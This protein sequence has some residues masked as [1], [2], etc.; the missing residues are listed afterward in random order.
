M[1]S[2]NGYPTVGKLGGIEREAWDWLKWKTYDLVF[3]P[4]NKKKPST[5]M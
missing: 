4:S 3:S 5:D 2:G 1:H